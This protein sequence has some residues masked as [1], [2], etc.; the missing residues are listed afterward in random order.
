AKAGCYPVKM[1]DC[2]WQG[3]WYTLSA[4][5]RFPSQGKTTRF[6]EEKKWEVPT[7]SERGME[8]RLKGESGP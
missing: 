7:A 2:R 5:S 8:G 1:L 6:S 4:L 3:C